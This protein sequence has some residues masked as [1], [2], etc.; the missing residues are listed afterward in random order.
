MTAIEED[1]MENAKNLQFVEYDQNSVE[2]VMEETDYC[3]IGA[4]T[5]IL[6]GVN[7]E[8]DILRK[9]TSTYKS[10]KTF[11][12]MLVAAEENVQS[13]KMTALAATLRSKE[14]RDYME[15]TYRGAYAVFE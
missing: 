1:I 14:I 13:E 7:I 4:D 8:E 3:I 6:A 11:A 12:T 10:A 15:E 5:A 2:S 9:E